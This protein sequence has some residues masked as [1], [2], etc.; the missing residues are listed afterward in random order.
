MPE[1]VKVNAI[2]NEID[3]KLTV[4]EFLE[5]ISKIN[6]KIEGDDELKELI[7]QMESEEETKAIM[8]FVGHT[9]TDWDNEEDSI[10]DKL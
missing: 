3:K 9:W 6:A 4:Q 1:S 7:M 8:R 10:Y 5:L 2:F